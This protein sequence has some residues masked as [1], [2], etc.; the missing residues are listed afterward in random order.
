MLLGLGDLIV[1]KG[2]NVVSNLDLVAA[3]LISDMMAGMVTRVSAW[4]MRVDTGGSFLMIAPVSSTT[5]LTGFS[6]AMLAGFPA[7]AMFCV[8]SKLF[9]E[10]GKFVALVPSRMLMRVTGFKVADFDA[11]TGSS[12]REVELGTMEV[13]LQ[14]PNPVACDILSGYLLLAR[15]E[16]DDVAANR[17]LIEIFII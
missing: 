9:F 3:S 16:A 12:N 8:C 13:F 11:N 17:W 2:F 7:V 10:I 4:L 1:K 14:L 5:V 6:L 15:A